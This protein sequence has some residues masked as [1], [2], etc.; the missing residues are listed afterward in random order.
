MKTYKTKTM[1]V[2]K[3]IWEPQYNYSKYVD[4]E[5]EYTY[6]STTYLRILIGILCLF[7]LC[8]R[9]VG[10]PILIVAAAFII[11]ALC[12]GLKNPDIVRRSET[13]VSQLFYST[14]QGILSTPISTCSKFLAIVIIFGALLERTGI[15]DF[16]I[17]I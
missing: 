7:E 4:K 10:L 12:G 1:E 16:F 3:L 8:R 17:K 14:T 2:E 11:Y 5:V 9:C 6:D 13:L 15:A